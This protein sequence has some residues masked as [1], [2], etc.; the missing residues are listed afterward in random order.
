MWLLIHTTGMTTADREHAAQQLLAFLGQ[1]GPLEAVWAMTTAVK[2]LEGQPASL[3]H[4]ATVA[5]AFAE[6]KTKTCELEA[7]TET[8][9]A[10]VEPPAVVDVPE[11]KKTTP[12]KKDAP[13]Q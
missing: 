3:D 4:V 5:Q 8:A 12:A 10:E 1:V 7:S 13:A 11:P 2:V 6:A 9:V